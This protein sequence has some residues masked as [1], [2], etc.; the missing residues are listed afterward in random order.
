MR[1]GNPTPE[2]IEAYHQI[3]R[4]TTKVFREK[5]GRTEIDKVRAIQETHKNRYAHGIHA[6]I[7]LH[8]KGPQIILNR[9]RGYFE[10]LLNVREQQMEDKPHEIRTAEIQDL[11][12]IIQEV[13]EAMRQKYPMNERPQL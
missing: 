2:N 8:R 3:N 1:Y 11:E 9:W 10:K 13:Q 6:G 7:N 5:R 4:E 12:P